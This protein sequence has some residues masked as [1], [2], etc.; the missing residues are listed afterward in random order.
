MLFQKNKNDIPED[1]DGFLESRL[2]EYQVTQ[3]YLKEAC[4]ALSFT[5]LE[6]DI[7]K[8]EETIDT[9]HNVILDAIEN[10]EQEEQKT[11]L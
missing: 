7:N 11:Q 2:R 10:G 1:I 5:E 3:G 6:I 4:R 9:M 8:F